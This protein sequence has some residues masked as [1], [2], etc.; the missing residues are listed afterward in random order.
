MKDESSPPDV[1]AEEIKELSV[2]KRD[3]KLQCNLKDGKSIQRGSLVD[4]KLSDFIKTIEKYCNIIQLEGEMKLA[5]EFFL[6]VR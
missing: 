3:A 5:C 4:G 1:N 2:R 6:S